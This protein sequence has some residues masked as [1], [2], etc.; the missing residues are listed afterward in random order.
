MTLMTSKSI[1]REF[2]PLLEQ[3]KSFNSKSHSVIDVVIPVFNGREHIARCLNSLLNSRCQTPYRLI[4][5]DDASTD[6]AL[7]RTLEFLSG[8][9]EFIYLRNEENQ[10]FVYSANRG[11]RYSAENDVVLLNSDTEVYNDWLDR[12]RQAAYG[13][14]NIATVTPLTNN[15]T[16]VS[17]PRFLEENPLPSDIDAKSLDRLAARLHAGHVV[18][19]PTAVG[20]C[21]YIRREALD[22]AGLFDEALFG[23]GYGEENDFSLRALRHGLIHVAAPSIFV[24]HEGGVSFGKEKKKLIREHL[25]ILN[26]KY[27]GYDSLIRSFIERDP[28]RPYRARLD[29]ARLRRLRRHSNIILLSHTR[30]GGTE[31]AVQREIEQ[32]NRN[33]ESVFR[34]FPVPGGKGRMMVHPGHAETGAMSNLGPFDL[35]DAE[36]RRKL[37]K[38]LRGLRL[39]ELVIHHT[40]DL[41][42]NAPDVLRRFS[43]EAALPYSFVIHDYLSVCPRVCLTLPKGIYCR[44]SQ[45]LGCRIC[46]WRYGSEFGRPR[47]ERWRNMWRRFLAQAENVY[48][49][50][51]DVIQRLERW[52]PDIPVRCAPNHP[53]IKG[54]IRIPTLSDSAAPLRIGILGA[55]G[56]TKGFEVLRRCARFIRRKHL[57]VELI[58]IGYTRHDKALKKLGVT[59]TG[60]YV[61]QD[62]QSLIHRHRPDCIF[63]PS[64]WPETYSF[65][66]SHALASG[67]PIVTFDIGAMGTRTRGLDQVLQLPLSWHD[68]PQLILS[69]IREWL[70][71]LS[72]RASE[73]NG[74]TFS[75]PSWQKPYA[76]YRKSLEEI[77]P[78]SKNYLIFFT[79]RSGS[80]YLTGLLASTG[81]LGNPQEWFNPR[82]MGKVM[83]ALGAPTLP[84]Y[85]QALLRLRKTDN[86]V[87]GGE[88]TISHME[89]LG[90]ESDFLSLWPQNLVPILLYRRDILLQAISLYKATE[91]GLFHICMGGSP[92][93]AP[94]PEKVPVSYDAERIRRWLLHIL[95]QEE[96]LLR[97]LNKNR[98]K[99]HVLH[100][101]QLVAAPPDDVARTFARWLDISLNACQPAQPVHCKVGNAENLAFRDTF[102]RT[103]KA[104]LDRINKRRAA[105]FKDLDPEFSHSF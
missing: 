70:L 53:P 67:L 58:V 86:G 83:H 80:S 9:L 102:A 62:I 72:K 28:L 29:E 32:R 5:I 82:W 60:P 61:D 46:L 63:L 40:I 88:C 38:I 64:I 91:T 84:D 105:L 39:R 65:T 78:A 85:I 52:L 34:L 57:P 73:L 79:P 75:E 100:Y 27:P 24:R 45:R 31:V 104:F 47:I 93:S 8:Q 42:A 74:R 13:K 94:P 37:S 20:F 15:G 17:Y 22:K 56:Y 44:D 89:R 21:M 69:T 103:E 6:E 98:L 49:P 71:D 87:F 76:S 7:S 97:F 16:I 41:G 18:E 96:K 50:N 4:I 55:I 90:R 19:I 25:K 33:N 66:L 77:R 12:L 30:G 10:G 99:P 59:I 1:L 11:M 101:E 26:R 68:A 23:R 81:C 92:P 48:A 51:V 36:D 2:S 95:H 14:N 54:T 3:S 35:Q 43:K